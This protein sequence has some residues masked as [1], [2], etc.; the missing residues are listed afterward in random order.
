MELIFNNPFKIEGNWYKGNIHIHTTNS[1]G[2]LSPEDMV[3]LYK[4]LGYDFLSITDHNKLT[5]VD[6][7]LGILLIP[8]EEVHFGRT[9][10]GSCFHI[11]ALNIN[12]EITPNSKEP[13]PQEIIKRIH[14]QGGE[15][16]LAHPYFSALIIDDLLACTECIGMEIF[17]SVCHFAFDKGY[18]LSHW[19]DLLATGRNVLGFAVDDAHYDPRS[20][21]NEIGYS[22]IMVKTKTLNVQ[23]IM[24]AIKKGLFYSSCGPK[25]ENLIIEENTIYVETSPVKS[26]SFISFNGLS[27]SFWSRKGELLNN[28]EYRI[29]GKE[30]F[31][32]IQ[33]R[34]TEHRMAW[35]NPI[36]IK[37]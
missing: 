36:I 22:W 18:A 34:D 27:I 1:N 10:A 2:R 3:M 17:N 12:Q 30:K 13:Q 25:F 21:S 4:N 24:D 37:V 33:C 23:E 5:K 28:I 6:K 16:I 11:V 7:D 8:G 32:R 26:I 29:T 31:I 35:L 19:D 20:Y 14:D 9:K 15:A